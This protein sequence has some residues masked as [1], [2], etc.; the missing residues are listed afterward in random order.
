MKIF[1]YEVNPFS[2]NTYLLVKENKALLFDP[3]FYTPA[4]M[5]IFLQ[6]LE[7]EKAELVGILLTHAHLDH[8]FGLDMVKNRFD[9]P[10]YLH[11][12]DNFFWDNYV[13][14]AE[15]FGFKVKP[16]EFRPEPLFPNS[17][18]HLHGFQFD[19][20]FTPGHAPGHLSYYIEEIKTVI[21]GD[22]L[23]YESIGRTDLYQG[24]FSVLESSIRKELYSLPN[25]T[26]VMP[27]HGPSTNIGHEKKHN[28]F[29]KI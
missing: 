25:E 23:F 6:T 17:D 22:A 3:G 29:V 10:V 18:F 15:M 20:R 8:V 12:E 19:V 1:T 2:E 9:V 16:F 26:I 27:G 21:S 24:N 28:P 7:Q 4:E 13:K 5:N 14:T 11:P